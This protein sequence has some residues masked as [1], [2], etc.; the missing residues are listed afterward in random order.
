MRT[1]RD[2]IE[3]LKEKVGRIIFN[4][5]STG[6]EIC[7]SMH[8]ED[9]YP[10]TTD[11]KNTSVEVS[12]IKRWVRPVAFQNWEEEL[13]PDGIKNSN[14]LGILRLVNEAYTYDKI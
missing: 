11:S 12:A 5:V 14:P 1:N 4:S 10:A 9:P 13:L 3:A 2:I 7:T 6:V 8:H